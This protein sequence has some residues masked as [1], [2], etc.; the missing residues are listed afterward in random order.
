[1]DNWEY[2]ITRFGRI[3]DETTQ[4]LNKYGNEG[5]ELVSVFEAFKGIESYEPKAYF[6]RKI[7]PTTSNNCLKS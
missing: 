4:L 7:I 2:K 6:K 5:W 3:D 1:M